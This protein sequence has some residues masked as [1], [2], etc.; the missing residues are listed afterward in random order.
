MRRSQQT[1]LG[2][3][4]EDIE[5]AQVAIVQVV[6]GAHLRDPATRG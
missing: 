1:I 5:K 6:V 2:L 4:A 3:P